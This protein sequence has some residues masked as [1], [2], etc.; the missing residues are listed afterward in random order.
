[1]KNYTILIIIFI[2]TISTAACKKSTTESES[3]PLVISLTPTHVSIFGGSD[4]AIDLTVEG[5][6]SP[7]EYEW[8]N[9]VD[10]KGIRNLTAGTYSVIVTDSD[11]Q[12]TTDSVYITEPEYS[13]QYYLGETLPSTTVTRFA[14]TIFTQELHAPPIF[15][16]NGDEVY[17]SLMNSNP[18]NILYKKIG[19]DGLWTNTAIAPFSHSEG[20]DSPVISPDGSKLIYLS[21]HNAQNHENIW[22]VEK[23]NGEWGTP[24]ML[25]N[26]INQFG[27]HW[28]TSIS[29]NQNL[30]FGA[31]GELYF[32]EYVDGNYT[33]AEK[34]NPAINTVDGHEQSP[35]IAPDE[36]YLIFGRANPYADLF[37]CFKN[38]DGS[39]SDPANIVE[40]NTTYHDMYA[41]VSPDGRFIMFLSQRTGGILLPYWVDASII[42]AYRNN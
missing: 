8:S 1:M 2:I 19:N 20:S 25:S 27:P 38:N 13:P 29:N 24:Y 6:I 17:W 36:S 21:A 34:L 28:G 41:N 35:Y 7:Y 23:E 31:E 22:I 4:G 3:E 33:T 9:G 26:E 39:W 30:Y 10:T 37:I 42:D 5:G 14:S 40:L 15:T 16:P 32:S 18:T 11:D 12:S